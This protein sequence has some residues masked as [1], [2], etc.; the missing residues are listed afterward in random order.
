M[1]LVNYYYSLSE[2]IYIL[3][4]SA[5]S[6]NKYIYIYYIYYYIHTY[7]YESLQSHCTGVVRIVTVNLE[8]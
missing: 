5:P 3:F 8:K 7:K 6:R 1:Q 4:L 2:K